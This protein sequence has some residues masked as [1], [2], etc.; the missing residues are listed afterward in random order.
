MSVS[1]AGSR[2][3]AIVTEFLDS[4]GDLDFDRVAQLLAD[5]AV[6]A[7]PFLESLP[8]THGGPAIAN[9]LRASVPRMFERMNFYYDAF[10]NVGDSDTLIAEY[11]SEC[12]LKG[13]SG[14]YRNRYITVFEFD[15]DRISLYKEYLNPANMTSGP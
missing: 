6:M 3:I 5:D 1:D 14:V 4:I 15:G 7:L 13:G 12:P 8:P 10:Y 11:H 2:R 9:Q